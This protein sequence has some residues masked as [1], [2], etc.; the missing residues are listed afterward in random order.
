MREYVERQL[1]EF[2]SLALRRVS[3]DED[4]SAMDGRFS[5]V[6]ANSGVPYESR[7]FE[8]F[9]TTVAHSEQQ[10]TEALA[11]VEALIAEGQRGL[12]PSVD[13]FPLH[14]V[15][16]SPHLYLSERSSLIAATLFERRARLTRVLMW[17]W[18]FG[19]AERALER[20]REKALYFGDTRDHLL[21]SGTS[22]IR[23]FLSECERRFP[24]ILSNPYVEAVG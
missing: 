6:P 8:A 14:L 9:G 16:R 20:L 22:H 2:G 10:Q 7:D 11:R 18:H 1:A 19:S 15:R 24:V 5:E 12:I 23:E 17:P 13:L 4:S 3:E 21:N